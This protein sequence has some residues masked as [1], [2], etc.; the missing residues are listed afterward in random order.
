MGVKMY[1]IFSANILG[2]LKNQLYFLVKENGQIILIHGDWK[3]LVAK[4]HTLHPGVP[5]D[6]PSVP[7][8]VYGWRRD[9]SLLFSSMKKYRI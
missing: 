4:H 2:L 7:C 8:K 3:L 1:L 9:N 6:I 5:D